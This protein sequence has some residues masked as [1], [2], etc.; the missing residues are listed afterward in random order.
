MSER[1]IIMQIALIPG[2]IMMLAF[3]GCQGRPAG[4]PSISHLVTITEPAVTSATPIMTAD[5][6]QEARLAMV[7][8]TI[9]ARGVADPVVLQA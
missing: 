9:V 7:E 6:Y 3:T 2:S 8:N 5:V 1:S 4:T